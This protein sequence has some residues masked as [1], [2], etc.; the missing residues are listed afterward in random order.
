MRSD[1]ITNRVLGDI[2]SEDKVREA[3]VQSWMGALPDPLLTRM[4]ATVKAALSEGRVTLTF[5][6]TRPGALSLRVMVAPLG[7]WIML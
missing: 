6:P 2:E 7:F 1:G 4:G 3:L 5:S